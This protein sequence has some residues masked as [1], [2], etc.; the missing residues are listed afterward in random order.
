MKANMLS[1]FL[2]RRGAVVKLVEHIST[3][4]KWRGFVS[5]WLYPNYVF[6]LGFNVQLGD[7]RSISVHQQLPFHRFVQRNVYKAWNLQP[8]LKQRRSADV[9]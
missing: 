6:V 8:S 3:T 2:S 1:I 5:R 7:H 4:S 9:D